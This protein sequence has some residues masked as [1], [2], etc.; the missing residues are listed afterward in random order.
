MAGNRSIDNY[1]GVKGDAGITADPETELAAYEYD[2][3]ATDA[4]Q[5]TRTSTKVD[6]KFSTSAAAPGELAVLSCQTQWGTSSAQHPVIAKTATGTYTITFAESYIDE[7]VNTIA[8]PVAET[9]V[10]AL[11]YARGNVMA[12]SDGIVRCT[13]LANVITVYVRTGGALSDL[14]G[15]VAVWVSAK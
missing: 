9:E 14:G 6:V 7:L 1:G 10:L 13:A 4:A 5:L 11:E 2:R 12:N 8:D 3:L 15:G